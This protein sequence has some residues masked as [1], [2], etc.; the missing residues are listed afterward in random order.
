MVIC[1]LESQQSRTY[2]GHKR[3]EICIF[4][5]PSKYCGVMER[6]KSKSPRILDRDIEPLTLQDIHERVLKLVCKIKKD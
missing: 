6:K 4:G 3:V 5:T 2:P 1:M